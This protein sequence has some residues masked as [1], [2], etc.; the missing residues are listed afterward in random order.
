MTRNFFL[1]HHQHQE[2]NTNDRKKL[3]IEHKKRMYRMSAWKSFQNE[4]CALTTLFIT[5]L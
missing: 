3:Y 4:F 2:M 1:Q 5:S